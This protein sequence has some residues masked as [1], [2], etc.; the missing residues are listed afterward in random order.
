MK[1]SDLR[2]VVPE[3]S[4]IRFTVTSLPGNDGSAD[5]V[6]TADILFFDADATIDPLTVTSL[7]A[8][9]GTLGKSAMPDNVGEPVLAVG[10]S[11][12]EQVFADTDWNAVFNG[13]V[14]RTAGDARSEI[15]AES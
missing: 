7:A 15:L 13:N 8:Q 11:C 5:S 12:S 6:Q 3:Q 1:L 10:L 2:K 14:V 4:L 9:P